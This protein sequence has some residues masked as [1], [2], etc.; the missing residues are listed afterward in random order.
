MGR[1]FAHSCSHRLL[2]TLHDQ[3]GLLFLSSLF[4]VLTP[5]LGALKFLF[6]ST[7][8]A[9]TPFL[10]HPFVKPA[11]DAAMLFFTDARSIIVTLVIMPLSLVWDIIDALEDRRLDLICVPLRNGGARADLHA[12]RVK[13]VQAQV[14]RAVQGGAKRLCTA[15]PSYLTMNA[16][17]AKYKRYWRGIDL[18]QLRDV[19]E[20]DTGRKIVK[21]EP[22]CSMGR[23]TKTLI[24]LGWTLPVLP[25]LDTLT[26][27]GLINGFGV[28]T[29]SHKY[30]L[31]NHTCV[32]YEIVLPSGE[33]IRCA[34]DMHPGLFAAIPWSHG[35]IG[36]LVSAEI[37]II[38]AKKYVHLRYTPCST[39]AAFLKTF[40]KASQSSSND[41][42]EALIYSPTTSVVMIGTLT[43]DL[44]APHRGSLSSKPGDKLNSIG[45]W[46]KPWFYTHAATYLARDCA[47]AEYIPLRDYY[48]RHTRS[49]FWEMRDIVPQ[50]N[51]FLYR[52]CFGWMPPRISLL[53]LTTV[54]KVKELYEQNHIAQD[55]LVPMSA[56]T[57]SL[58]IFD[59]EFGLYP[60][61]VCPMRL[62][63][64]PSTKP[65]APLPQKSTGRALPTTTPPGGMC[66]PH[67]AEQ[68]Y[69]DIGA[70][71]VPASSN[72]EAQRSLRKVEAFVRSVKGY[73]ALY[74]DT[75][76]TSEEFEEM[77]ECE[78][79]ENTRKQ[80]GSD[81]L[82]PR[83]WEKVNAAA[84]H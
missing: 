66:P 53:K 58:D 6:V 1:H 62:L 33:L 39:H 12:R 81:L 63:S 16:R 57:A 42:V 17:F 52:L 38:P 83:V 72:F 28:E 60:L 35:T 51:N 80:F 74:A 70:Y 34:R 40:E 29:S 9:A 79:L 44:P 36:F 48:H 3:L 15:R 71:G 37:T 77:F 14:V 54:G 47:G 46:Y 50:G 2:S 7:C 55:M 4:F 43:D 67:P 20:V 41:F 22:G 11:A 82:L 24:P 32:A 13:D 61:W 76:M 31:F 65:V 68:L 19:V 10:A 27:G 45:R 78:G 30:G 8:E 18:E 84:R 73:Q 5:L 59:R 25:E 75:L 69:V 21:V 26:V 64:P 23:L 56:L 49:L